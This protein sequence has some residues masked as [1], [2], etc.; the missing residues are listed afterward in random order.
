MISSELKAYLHEFAA[1]DQAKMVVLTGAGISAESGI[2]TF[3]GKEGY[4]KIGS[5]NYQPQDIGTM[6]MFKQSPQEVWKWYLFRHTVCNNAQPNPGHYAVAEMEKVLGGKRFTLVTQNVDGLHFRAGSTFKNTLLIHGDLTH[7]RCSKDSCD[8]E[9]LPFP[10]G[11]A[12]KNRESDISPEE[13]ELLKCVNCGALTRPHV[14]WFDEYYNEKYY[15]YETAL[16]KNKEADLLIVVGTSGA[17]NL[18]NK[19]YYNALNNNKQIVVVNLDSSIFSRT[20]EANQ[21][22]HVLL[23]KS[24]EILPEILA[25]IKDTI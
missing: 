21:T 5:V 19:M 14:L 18:P 3:R 7:V 4:W 22:G 9:L 16:H 11:I 17:T 25:A 24:G 1:N 6:K 13:W 20:L 23:G 10:K 8:T 2:P 15:K 12:P